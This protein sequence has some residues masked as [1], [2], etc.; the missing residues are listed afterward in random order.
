MRRKYIDTWRTIAVTL[1]IFS[2]LRLN[3]NFAKMLSVL[4]VSFLTSYGQLGVF[5]FFFISGYIVSHTCF[6]ELKK[7]GEFCIRGFYIRRVYRIAPPLLIYLLT[8]LVLGRAEIIVFPIS[9]GL[10]SAAYLCNISQQLFPC[11][12]YTG[13]TWSLAFEEQ[14]YLLFPTLFA[15]IQLG[16]RVHPA[17]AVVVLLSIMPMALPISWIGRSG[18]VLIYALFGVGYFCAKYEDQLVSILGRAPLVFISVSI[19]ITFM[20][21]G[22]FDFPAL[23]KYYKFMYIASVPLMVLAS[24]QVSGIFGCILNNVALAYI[25]RIS[26]SIYLWQQI[27][28][29]LPFH[30]SSLAI[31]LFAIAL[32]VLGCALSFRF[33]EMPLIGIGRRRSRAIAST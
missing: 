32:V 7:T 21:L 1:V 10:V 14:F 26:Y 23:G 2:H 4:D 9:E 27:V 25:G 3:S 13:H 11:G 12:W 22:I 30:E 17:T 18:F 16:R 8:C 33:I 19:I 6:Q 29:S 5:I 24:S 15:A 31:Q 28:T 20:P